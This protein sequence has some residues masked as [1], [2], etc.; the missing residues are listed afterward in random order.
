ME[1]VRREIFVGTAFSRAA[2]E[3]AFDRFRELYNV[4]PNRVV[5][6]PDALARY[7]AVYERSAH[8]AMLHSS[9]LAYEG[10]P[11]I[12]G[13]IAPGTI[14]FEGEVDEERMGDW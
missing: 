8:V 6:S 11:L 4:R 14:A 10:I 3:R 1:Q 12:A 13:I 9:R 5:C 7:C 2:F